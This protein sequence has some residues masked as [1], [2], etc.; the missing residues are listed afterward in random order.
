MSTEL[1]ELIDMVT[2]E[3]GVEEEDVYKALEQALLKIA[4]E[5]YGDSPDLSVIVDRNTGN[6]DLFYAYTVTD[7]PSH[8]YEISHKEANLIKHGAE[9][10]EKVFKKL[11]F[12]DFSRTSKK[13][14]AN[15]LYKNLEILRR[16]REYAEFKD[17][18]GEMVSG[19]VKRTQPN[20]DL[21][22]TLGKGIGYLST[23]HLLPCEISDKKYRPG[24]PIKVY[25]LDVKEIKDTKNEQYQITLSRTHEQFLA[26][27]LAMEV[28]EIQDGSVEIKGV[29]R[30]P[31]IR[32]KIAVAATERGIDPLGA[33]IGAKGARISNVISE[34]KGEC[35][36]VIY[37]SDNVETFAINALK[38]A[39]IL[40]AVSIDDNLIITVDKE[41]KHKAIGFKGS[42]ILL[43]AALTKM[44]I[45]IFTEEE[46]KAR[47][48]E[49]CR[50][51][52]LALNIEA[53]M[54]NALIKHGFENI[55][56]L[57]SATDDEL[58]VLPGFDQDIVTALRERVEAYLS[59]A[60]AFYS[61]AK[62]IDIHMKHIPAIKMLYIQKLYEHGVRKMED[63]A[64]LTQ[65]QMLE[66]LQDFD[67]SAITAE[68][69]I[70]YAQKKVKVLN[71][72]VERSNKHTAK[73]PHNRT[74]RFTGFDK[75]T[76]SFHR[77]HSSGQSSKAKI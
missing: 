40:R 38:P 62:D 60:N 59:Q 30:M 64:K 47:N 43:A 68:K 4:M 65:E 49:L 22:V 26:K 61:E 51:L 12:T 28:P 58:A 36:D 6:V 7:T 44:R 76:K 23:Q 56:D 37:W 18:I 8:V 5:R 63:I 72:S 50:F 71:A 55:K 10:G 75:R 57:N 31:G 13:I 69:I 77:H 24:N 11:A 35:I 20:G 33:C 74:E 73:T 27:L 25:V 67:L 45:S 52:V 46:E 3:K 21:I 66:Y 34:L 32:A 9:I 15:E 1:L 16:A 19:V 70:S 54:A 53:A 48:K 14:A 29:V 41:Q 17:K 39:E 2:R 42:N